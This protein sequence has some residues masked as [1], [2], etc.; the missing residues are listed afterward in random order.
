[1][2]TIIRPQRRR[3]V[4]AVGRL[5]RIRGDDEGWLAFPCN[6]HGDVDRDALDDERRAQLDACL[7]GVLPA[8]DFGRCTYEREEIT[9]A[10]LRCD[11]GRDIELRDDTTVCTVCGRHFAA[12]GSLIAGRAA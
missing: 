10:L 8:I 5:F 11:C 2:S 6:E 3:A 1:M 9:P 7:S 12:D 4:L